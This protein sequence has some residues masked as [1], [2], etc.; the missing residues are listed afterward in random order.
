[1]H[2]VRGNGWTDRGALT[3]R[4]TG[5]K[6]AT[7]RCWVVIGCTGRPSRARR[8]SSDTHHCRALM[9]GT[10]YQK[11]QGLVHETGGQGSD[12]KRVS[13]STADIH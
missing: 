11:A 12:R 5:E 8:R 13:Y 7:P 9:L 10:C 2:C 1:M 3:T 4:A 6:L